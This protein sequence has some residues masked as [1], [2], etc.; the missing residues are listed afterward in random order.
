MRQTDAKPTRQTNGLKE[1]LC[2]KQSMLFHKL[3]IDRHMERWRERQQADRWKD[4]E[5]DRFRAIE[6][7]KWIEKETIEQTN[8]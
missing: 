8:H 7:E 6:T 5:K 1:R 2:A 3:Q 4:Y